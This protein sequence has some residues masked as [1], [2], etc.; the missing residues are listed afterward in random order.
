[1]AKKNVD[2]VDA[3]PVMDTPTADT[4]T[5]DTPTDT[6]K[7]RVLADGVFGRVNDVVWVALAVARGCD[8]LDTDAAAVAYAESLHH[9][10][11]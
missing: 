6:V 8:V 2:K 11:D 10:D 7:A 9:A 5:A 3:L 4:P 1:M